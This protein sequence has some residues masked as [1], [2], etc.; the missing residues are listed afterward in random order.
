[1]RLALLL[2]IGSTYTKGK[3]VDLDQLELV[4]EA[5]TL[6]TVH[7]N[8]M[9]GI[10]SIYDELKVQ[11]IAESNISHRIASSSAAGGLKMIA[12][13]LVPELTAEAAKRAALGAGAKVSN[14]YAYELS[15]GDIEKIVGEQPDVLLLAGGTDGGKKDI[16]IHNAKKLGASPLNAPVIMAGNKAAADQVYHILTEHGKACH[17]TE[18]VMPELEKLNIEPARDLIRE[19]F[20]NQIIYAKGFQRVRDHFGQIIMPT[21]AA[22][23]CAAELLSKGTGTQEGLG[24]IMIVDIGGATTDVHSAA[25]GTPSSGISWKGLEEPFVKRTVEG[26][27][28]MRYSAPALLEAVGKRHIMAYTNGALN[29]EQIHTY[30]EQ[31]SNQ[32]AYLPGPSE[33]ELEFTLARAAI[34]LA[35]HR[36][37]GQIEVHYTPFGESFTQRG[38]DLTELKFIIGTGGVLVHNPEAEGLIRT[39]FVKCKE[40]DILAP[41]DCRVSIDR[42]YLL[43]TIG[44]LSQI[45]EDLGMAFAVKHLNLGVV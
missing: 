35:V 33:R 36:H 6:T 27:L 19:I 43:S 18:N 26:D 12:C 15:D 37:V 22:V 41:K 34:D 42:Q 10:H 17:V 14:V 5:K 2:D 4:G 24:E 29:Y 11:G 21:P 45:D 32:V 28:G 30:V 25:E 13:G 16:V 39:S 1:M 44:L 23:M 9:R 20:L 7:D 8:V 40:P 38:K 3:V 31:L